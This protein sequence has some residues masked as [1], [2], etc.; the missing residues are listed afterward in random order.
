MAGTV[1]IT[2]QGF[3]IASRGSLPGTC[4]WRS[5]VPSWRLEP[6]VNGSLG[7]LSIRPIDEHHGPCLHNV[8]RD[9]HQIRVISEVTRGHGSAAISKCWT[10]TRHRVEGAHC[11]H[12]DLEGSSAWPLS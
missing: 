11:A 7:N 3:S 2:G 4:I 8:V 9:N 5:G 10:S 1:M 12:R 6:A